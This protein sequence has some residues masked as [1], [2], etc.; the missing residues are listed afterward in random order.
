MESKYPE[1]FKQLYERK[2]YE[3]RT[4]KNS[5]EKVQLLQKKIHESSANKHTI[6]KPSSVLISNSA[7]CLTDVNEEQSRAFLRQVLNSQLKPKTNH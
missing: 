4:P 5:V 6:I 2:F 3:N 7:N 1:L